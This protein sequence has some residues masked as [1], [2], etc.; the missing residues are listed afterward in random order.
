MRTSNWHLATS[1]W[2]RPETS[3]Q[4][5]A[6]SIRPIQTRFPY[7]FVTRGECVEGQGLIGETD[8]DTR[9]ADVNIKLDEE[10]CSASRSLLM[11]LE[12]VGCNELLPRPQ[13]HEL[14]G[15]LR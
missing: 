13:I 3:N 5:P 2:L 9:N 15:S 1:I 6:T 11:V 4:S 12:P 14:H 10:W 8:G 7:A